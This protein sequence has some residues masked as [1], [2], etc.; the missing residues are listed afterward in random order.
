MSLLIDNV[1]IFCNDDQRRL[2]TGHALWIDGAVIR[3]IAPAAAMSALPAEI[4]RIDGQ[5]RLLLPGWINAHMHFYGTYARGIA[6]KASPRNFHEILKMLWWKL[7]SALDAEAVYYSA[8]VPA[9]TA[10]K[11]GVTAVV[12]H[13][14]SP[15]AIDGSLDR[16]E[17]ALLQVGLRGVLCY[18]V[19]DRDGPEVRRRGLEENRR[20]LKKCREARAA[21][22]THPFDGMVG[23]HASFTLDDESLTSAAEM[24]REFERGCHIHVLEDGVDGEITGRK[25]GRSV[26]PRL[27]AA[28]ILGPRSI[29]AHCIHIGEADR[30]ILAETDSIV[31]HNPQSN[32]NNAVGRADIFALLRHGVLLGIGT[33]G[34]SADIWPDVRTANLLHKHGLNS[35]QAGWAEI[36]QM[37]LH[38]NPEI[39]R[40]LTGLPVGRILPGHPADVILVD[41]YPPTPMTSENIWGHFLFGIA[42]APVDTSIING[43]VVLRNKQL[44]GIDEAKIAA[45]SRRVAQR[46]WKTFSQ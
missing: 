17:E 20:Y 4:T 28:G 7:D 39:Y 34:M 24:S 36:Q 32:M 41:Y 33:D 27:Q 29:A 3:E 22:N 40:R 23:L 6:M 43:K 31:V 44:I 25:Y 42:D 2:L 45:E 21:D 26:V 1:T 9:L 35:S 30:E 12:D 16:I 10:V 38:N 15:N 19:S 5:G 8:L 11:R 37:L 13:H 14:A 18:E 46:V